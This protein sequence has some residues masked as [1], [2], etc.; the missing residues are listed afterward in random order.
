MFAPKELV[1]RLQEV[2]SDTNKC[3]HKGP[4]K[5]GKDCMTKFSPVS[6]QEAKQIAEAL[7]SKVDATE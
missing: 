1:R 4:H 5:C 6:V 2:C 7:R 3:G